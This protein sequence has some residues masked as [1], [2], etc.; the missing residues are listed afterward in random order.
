MGE[1]SRVMAGWTGRH[2][3]L[4]LAARHPRVVPVVTI[5]GGLQRPHTRIADAART[6]SLDAE[7]C[8]GS[9]PGLGSISVGG[10]VHLH[11]AS[12]AERKFLECLA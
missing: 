10:N 12:I 11:R 8:N 7:P 9:R 1:A 3:G 2:P 6:M 5:Y 4:A